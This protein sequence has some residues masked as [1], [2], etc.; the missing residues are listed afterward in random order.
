[1]PIKSFKKIILRKKLKGF[2]SRTCSFVALKD[3]S[4]FLQ[5]KAYKSKTKIN[6]SNFFY[7]S[8]GEAFMYL[9]RKNQHCIFIYTNHIFIYK[10]ESLHTFINISVT[11]VGCLKPISYIILLGLA[12]KSC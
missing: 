12:E 7:I 4:V 2:L 9:H 5:R 10:S 6:F 3:H 1:M 8:K 11:P